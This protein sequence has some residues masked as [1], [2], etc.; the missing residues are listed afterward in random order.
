MH[1]CNN[2]YS[3]QTD[4][5]SQVETAYF[6]K[7]WKSQANRTRSIVRDLVHD[8]RLELVNG[9]WSMNDEATAHYQSIIDQF[10]WGLK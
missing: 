9:A 3:L 8:G 10:A 1:V 5:F 6:S 4:R 2:K 7:W